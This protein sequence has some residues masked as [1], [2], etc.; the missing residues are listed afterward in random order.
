MKKYIT[1]GIK[2]CAF[3]DEPVLNDGTYYASD[4]EDEEGEDLS[5]KYVFDEDNAPKEK[6]VWD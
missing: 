6:S 4:D 5:N 3:Y 1:P 2:E